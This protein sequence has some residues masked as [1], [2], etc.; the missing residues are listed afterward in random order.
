MD[1]SGRHL[2]M[3]FINQGGEGTVR[4]SQPKQGVEVTGKFSPWGS[5]T[6]A[7]L[8]QPHRSSRIRPGHVCTSAKSHPRHCL[9]P[10]HG[11]RGANPQTGLTKHSL[12]LIS[13]SWCQSPPGLRCCPAQRDLGT[14]LGRT[15]T[16]PMVPSLQ[17]LQEA[18]KERFGLNPMG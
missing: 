16:A 17:T 11:V 1:G 10:Q 14:P 6:C 3:W 15:C 5:A 18:G 8:S 9:G 12:S 13:L 7:V 4:V 2:Q